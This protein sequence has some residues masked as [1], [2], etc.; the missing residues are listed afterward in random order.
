[1]QIHKQLLARVVDPGPV[2]FSLPG[3]ENRIRIFF[4]DS[5]PRSGQILLTRK[6]VHFRKLVF[7]LD[8]ICISSKQLI[9]SIDALQQPIWAHLVFVLSIPSFVLELNTE[10]LKTVGSGYGFGGSTSL[11]LASHL[12]ASDSKR[13]RGFV[14]NAWYLQNGLNRR[15]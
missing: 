5:D 14:K 8:Y 13:S 3:S 7:V 1:M 15:K 10:R 11:L 12:R 6:L 2:V 4:T 9:K